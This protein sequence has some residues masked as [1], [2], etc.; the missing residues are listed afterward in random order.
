MSDR[1]TINTRYMPTLGNGHIAVTVYDNALYL[2]GLYEG[3]GGIRI[4]FISLNWAAHT[5]PTYT[6]THKHKLK[7]WRVTQSE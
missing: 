3:T 4:K 6:L 1:A 2:N 7:C 5:T